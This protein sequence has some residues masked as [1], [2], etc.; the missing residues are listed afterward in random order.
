MSAT[1]QPL[2]P[3]PPVVPSGYPRDYERRLR[4][5]DGRHVRIRPIVPADAPALAAA[6]HAADPDTLHRRFLGGAPRV[7]PALLAHLTGLDY[8]RRFALGAADAV[9]GQGVAIA[10]YEPLHEGVA[11]VAVVVDPAWRG[12]GLATAL[13]ETLAEAALDRGIDTF[14]AT[15]L[16]E[17]RPVTALVRLVGPN[18]RQ[19]IR[20]GIAEFSIALD[21]EQVAR[22]LRA[23]PHDDDASAA[24]QAPSET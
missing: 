16:A 15:V 23:L 9:T 2:D 22:A 4:L 11:E 3:H 17:N 6:I 14:C 12:V 1:E 13:V 8:S 7:T 21:R 18:V 10:R 24:D 5:A 19:S 20:E